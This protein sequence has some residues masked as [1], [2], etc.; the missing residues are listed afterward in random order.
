M[1]NGLMHVPEPVLANVGCRLFA[2]GSLMLVLIALVGCGPRIVYDYIPPEST[3]GRVCTSQCQ[4]AASNCR[5]MKQ[6]MNQ[7]CQ[8][9]YSVMQQN[10]NACK[11]SGAK[12]CVSPSPCPYSSTLACDQGY[13]ECFA[14]CGGKVIARVVE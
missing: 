4:N 10:Y 8:N 11:E 14:A 13:R 1:E 9:N 2:R 6:I 7:Q 3:E 12:H 5:Q